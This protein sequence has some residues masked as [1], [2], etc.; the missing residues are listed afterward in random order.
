M[1]S[2]K[3]LWRLTFRAPVEDE[4]AICERL[5]A[6]TGSY[7]ATRQ[8]PRAKTVRFEAYFKNRS[9]LRAAARLLK[10]HK[11]KS[12]VLPYENWAESWK[13]HFPIQRVGKRII[14]KPSW[15]KYLARDRDIVVELDPGMSFGTGQHST[16]R[17][18]LA[19]LER[20]SS[21]S[22]SRSPLSL[23][24][25]GT[26]S[27]ILAIAGIKMGFTPVLAVD[28]DPQA[29][30][31]AKQNATNNGVRFPISLRPL[32][33]IGVSTQFDVVTANL[34]ADLILAQSRRLVSLVAPGGFLI[35][36]GILTRESPE[37]NRAFR[38]LG[39]KPSAFETRGNWTGIA[40]RTPSQ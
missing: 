34:L 6:I 16:T 21:L 14:I 31:I 27:G 39:C 7:P 30:R 37:I 26:G 19:R 38:V 33:A 9:Q 18:C 35:L 17:F 40:F 20:L 25:V 36:A 13:K 12:G 29:V 8:R 10:A 5:Y 22:A 32:E 11:P 28:N 2:H 1:V 3:A 24:D 23:L 15:R 4:E